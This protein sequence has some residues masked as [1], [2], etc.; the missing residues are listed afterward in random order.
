MYSVL[1]IPD[2]LHFF[3]LNVLQFFLAL[4]LGQ[5]GAMIIFYHVRTQIFLSDLFY[6]LGANVTSI[7]LELPVCDEPGEEFKVGV[8]FRT[9]A[10]GPQ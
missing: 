6:I 4:P 7:T 2:F 10:N 9:G 5:V 8:S 1:K 3:C